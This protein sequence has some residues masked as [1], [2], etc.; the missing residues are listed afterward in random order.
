MKFVLFMI[1]LV[2]TPSAFAV[3][4]L[5]LD[6]LM[7]TKVCHHC[8][9]ADADLQN[10]DLTGADMSEALLKNI[11]LNGSTLVGVWFTRSRLQGAN[12]EKANLSGALFDYALLMGANFK[13]ANF[14][15]ATLNFADLTDADLTGAKIED[16][17]LRGV[18]YCN[19]TM[20]NG[21]INNSGCPTPPS[22][23]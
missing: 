22:S 7:D 19:T 17:V 23:D 8:N 3:E 14:K 2:L 5:Y 11:N 15:G 21:D 6:R 20:P 4:Q 18:L 12:F 9:L 16:A 10:L 13:K 1:S